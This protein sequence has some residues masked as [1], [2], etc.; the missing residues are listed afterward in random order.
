[1]S[2]SK[3]K[4]PVGGVTA[5]KSEKEW[6]QSVNRKLRHAAERV[7]RQLPSGDADAAILPVVNEIATP[8]HGPKEGK[9]RFDTDENPKRMRK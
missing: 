8:W 1:M 6:K 5:A 9:F 2:R 3:Q 7:V 4:S